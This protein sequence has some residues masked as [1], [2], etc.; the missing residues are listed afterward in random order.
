MYWRRNLIKLTFNTRCPCSGDLTLITVVLKLQSVC[1]R[2]TLLSEE[3]KICNHASRYLPFLK[4]Q[5]LS[6]MH[7]FTPVS[8]SIFR[9]AQFQSL[10]STE[11][12]E[13]NPFLDALI[14]TTNI[15]LDFSYMQTSTFHLTVICLWIHIHF[16]YF[17]RPEKPKEEESPTNK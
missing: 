11:S 17:L 7:V 1:T 8:E 14:L 4:L 15:I 5:C 12:W 3:R 13:I 6:K 16:W 10:I 2:Q 9:C